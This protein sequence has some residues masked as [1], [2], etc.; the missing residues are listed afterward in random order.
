MVAL[1]SVLVTGSW[2]IRTEQGRKLRYTYASVAKWAQHK[3]MLLPPASLT[4]WLAWWPGQQLNFKTLVLT[5]SSL[6]FLDS[7]QVLVYLVGRK[8]TLPL[9]QHTTELE[10]WG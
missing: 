9:L 10:A 4:P 1:M 5:V 6:R 2:A 8:P 3:A 7:W